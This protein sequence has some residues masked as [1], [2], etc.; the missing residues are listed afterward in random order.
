MIAGGDLR[1]DAEGGFDVAAAAA[2]EFKAAAPLADGIEGEV[3]GEGD[4]FGEVFVGEGWA[5]D[6]DFLTEFFAG[7]HGF[8]RA[9][10]AGTVEVLADERVGG[11]HAEALLGEEDAA[12][13]GGFDGGEVFEVPAEPAEVD[14]EGWS[15]DA[16][17]VQ[18]GTD[19]VD[20]AG[21]GGHVRRR[22]GRAGFR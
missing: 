20:W 6:V 17:E 3:V 9:A 22:C 16:R 7:E 11:P 15:G 10:G 18:G 2:D 13:G 12:T 5:V 21:D 8:P 14:D 4:D 19:L 1:I